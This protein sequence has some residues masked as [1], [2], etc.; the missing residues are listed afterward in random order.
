LDN[1]FLAQAKILRPDTIR[2]LLTGYSDIDDT[3]RSINDGEIFRYVNK[4][5]QA[6]KLP[7][8]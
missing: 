3:I 5:W 7:K 8:Q 4:P 1:E 6:A 2:I